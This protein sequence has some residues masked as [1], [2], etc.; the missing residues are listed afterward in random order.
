MNGT[1]GIK[2]SAA[3][4]AILPGYKLV[5]NVPGLPFIEP[6]FASVRRVVG[7]EKGIARHETETEFARFETE[8]HGVA[9]VVT[10]EQWR[11]LLRTETSY[12]CEDVT[13]VR[14][15]HDD[16]DDDDDDDNDDDA[17]R[18]TE[19][20]KIR[21]AATT[22]VFPDVDV[23]GVQLLPSAR[24]L[25]VLREGAMEWNLDQTWRR[26]LAKALKSYDPEI[27]AS[28]TLGAAVAAVSLAPIAAFS[29]PVSAAV[30][31]KSAFDKMNGE[32]T[33]TADDVVEAALGGGFRAFSQVAWG[34]HNAL[35][36]PVFGSGANNDRRPPR[37]ETRRARG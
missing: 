34:V 32:E 36:A 29:A 33:A 37:R 15:V 2:P 9:Y 16:D 14:F 31:A 7:A 1:R 26:Y 24:Y 27:S 8:T 20:K 22:L 18:A 11:Y 4:P 35:W 23:G 3:Y 21:I 30:A 17:S 13:C 28:R 19:K 10:D 12:V 25:N 5:F 6:A